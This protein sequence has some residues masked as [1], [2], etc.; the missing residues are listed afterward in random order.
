MSFYSAIE[1]IDCKEELI[2]IPDTF[3]FMEPHAYEKLGAP[4]GLRSPFY[5]RLGVVKRLEIALTNLHKQHPTWRIKIF[6]AYRPVAVQEFMVNHTKQQLI[7][8][9]NIDINDPIQVQAV[10]TKVYQFWAVPS[11]DPTTPPPHSTGAAVDLTLV[12]ENGKDVDMGG[13]IDEISDRSKPQYYKLATT[14]EHRQFNQHRQLLWD[15][16]RYAGFQR[17]PNEWWHFSY[18]D[19]MWCWLENAANP[20]LQPQTA[21]YGRA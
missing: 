15:C 19:Q 13:E 12:D 18:G 21:R 7:Q 6:D 17:H 2:K 8:E 4:Y 3:L 20:D 1:I 9:L 14:S 16:M 10:M 11:L 5:L